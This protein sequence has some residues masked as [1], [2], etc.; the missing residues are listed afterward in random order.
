MTSELI[1]LV[2]KL[3]EEYWNAG[4]YPSIDEL[5]QELNNPEWEKVDKVHN[6]KNYIPETV[7]ANWNSLCKE[8]QIISWFMANEQA[9]CEVWD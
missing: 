8:S 9:D 5:E 7:Q 6:W 2:T 1:K 4:H 3:K